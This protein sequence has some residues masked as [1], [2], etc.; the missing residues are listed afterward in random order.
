MAYLRRQDNGLS[1]L[2]VRSFST[3]PGSEYPEEPPD[4][5]GRRGDVIHVYNDDGAFGDMG[6]MECNG[7]TIGGSTGRSE[8][9]DTLA[10][11]LFAGPADRLQA[12]LF[13][14]LGIELN[15]NCWTWYGRLADEPRFRRIS[16]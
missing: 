14:M 13:E 4:V 15:L 6:E 8:S 5:P 7:Q 9:T 11:Y 1:Y 2:L 16:R 3:H 12:I 10:L